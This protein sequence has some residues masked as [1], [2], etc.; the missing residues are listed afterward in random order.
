MYILGRGVF[1]DYVF[2]GVDFSTL[3]APMEFKLQLL[4]L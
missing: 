1:K 2:A 3:Y 4:F